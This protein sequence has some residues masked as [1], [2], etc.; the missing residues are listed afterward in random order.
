MKTTVKNQW[1]SPELQRPRQGLYLHLPCKAAQKQKRS[2]GFPVISLRNGIIEK[3][4]G[5]R[6]PYSSQKPD[7]RDFSIYYVCILKKNSKEPQVNN[8]FGFLNLTVSIFR[9]NT[10]YLEK[11]VEI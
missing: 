3:S 9:E 5:V 8:G 10:F 1:A 4:L 2:Q 7:L 6:H 11:S